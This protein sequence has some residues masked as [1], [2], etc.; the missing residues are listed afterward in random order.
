VPALTAA[1]TALAAD[2]ARRAAM[3][4]AGHAWAE[5]FAWPRVVDRLEAA[6]QAA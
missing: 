1:L 5:G 2:P 6:Y 4:A 3:G